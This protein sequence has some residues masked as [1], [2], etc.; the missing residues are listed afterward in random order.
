[1]PLEHAWAVPNR[2]LQ[3]TLSGELAPADLDDSFQ[4]IATT[5]DEQVSGILGHIILD[6]RTLQLTDRPTQSFQQ[7]FPLARSR[8]LGWLMLVTETEDNPLHVALVSL[9]RTH[10]LRFRLFTSVNEA[11]QF[12]MGADSTLAAAMPRPKPDSDT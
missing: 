5:F 8:R 1:M 6:I 2:V 12:V 3:A 9:A 11:M 4:Q 7:H 10:R